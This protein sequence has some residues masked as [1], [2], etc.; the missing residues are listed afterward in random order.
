MHGVDERATW[1]ES[2]IG[3]AAATAERG[4]AM[5]R[6]ERSGAVDFAIA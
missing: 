5:I 6:D 3:A 4:Y 1:P 2:S